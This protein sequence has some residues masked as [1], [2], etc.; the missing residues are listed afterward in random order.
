M[1]NR[2]Q[3]ARYF[4]SPLPNQNSQERL[5][6]YT[7]TSISG[8]KFCMCFSHSSMSVVAGSSLSTICV[9][10]LSNRSKLT[11][12]SHCERTKLANVTYSAFFHSLRL[13]LWSHSQ[14]KVPSLLQQSC[15]PRSCSCC[16]TCVD[17]LGLAASLLLRLVRLVLLLVAR[18]L[19]VLLSRRRLP[20]LLLLLRLAMLFV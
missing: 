18:R 17:C 4:V 12:P 14:R 3:N 9:P 20:C 11:S 6:Y 13:I 7:L 2:R 1:S 19:L 8:M 5:S 15:R 10:H 16:S